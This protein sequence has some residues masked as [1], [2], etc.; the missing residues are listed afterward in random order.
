MNKVYAWGGLFLGV[1]ILAVIYWFYKKGVSGVASATVNAA[2]EAVTGAVEG[3][4]QTVGIPNTSQDKCSADLAG[5]HVWDASFD[6]SAPAFFKGLFGKNNVS[7][8]PLADGKLGT[9]IGG[10]FAT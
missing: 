3:I 1:L 8:Q 4:A 9:G 5:G 7:L 6:C 10:G 2:G